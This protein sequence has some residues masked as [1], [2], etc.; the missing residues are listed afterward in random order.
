M[1]KLKFNYGNSTCAITDDSVRDAQIGQLTNLNTTSKTNLVSAINEVN[2]K[3]F[4]I[5]ESTSLFSINANACDWVNIT[6]SGS[7]VTR[8]QCAFLCISGQST[9]CEII[10]VSFTGTGGYEET[11][12]HEVMIPYKFI[13][14]YGLAVDHLTVKIPG[15][16]G[17]SWGFGYILKTVPFSKNLQYSI[18]YSND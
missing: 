5:Y 12:Q 10:P 16:F 17:G 3:H 4:F 11:L 15:G 1:A 2:N 6:F 14:D 7:A 18:S 13:S 8:V 9:L